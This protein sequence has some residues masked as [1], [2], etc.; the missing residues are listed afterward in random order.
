MSDVT[1]YLRRLIFSVL[2]CPI[3]AGFWILLAMSGFNF[4][5]FMAFLGNMSQHYAAMNIDDQWSFQFQILA[6]WGV[7]AFGF[8]L[9]NFIIHPPQFDYRLVKEDDHWVTDVVR[10]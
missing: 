7:L 6:S 2:L 3:A 10:E 4:S 1:D 9:L 8:F 5:E